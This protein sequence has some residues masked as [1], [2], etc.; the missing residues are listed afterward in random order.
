MLNLLRL[1][2]FLLFI[3]CCA[4]T[5]VATDLDVFLS[6]NCQ[7]PD[8][9]CILQQGISGLPAS[10]SATFLDYAVELPV[11]HGKAY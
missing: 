7:F 11:P 8:G 9:Q 6:T 5:A 1:T 10:G 2:L 3:S 4:R